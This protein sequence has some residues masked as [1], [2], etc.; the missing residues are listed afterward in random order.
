MS[1]RPLYNAAHQA[2]I[3]AS[4][5]EAIDVL[6]HQSDGPEDCTISKRAR[7]SL[8]PII[9]LVIAQAWALNADLERADQGAPSWATAEK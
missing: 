3:L 8:G 7:N 5:V 2:C 1:D 4:M 6:H 9:D